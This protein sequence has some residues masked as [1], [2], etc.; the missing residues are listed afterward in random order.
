MG[1]KLQSISVEDNISFEHNY[2][3]MNECFGRSMKGDLQQATYDTKDGCIA[4]FPFIAIEKNGKYEAGSKNVN[5]KNL[6][7]DDGT[8]ITQMLYPGEPKKE[9]AKDEPFLTRPGLPHHTFMKFGEHNFKYVGTFVKDMNASAPRSQLLRRV[10]DHIDLS[11]WYK[12]HD[13][14]YTDFSETGIACLKQ[15]YIEN[16]LNKHKEKLKEFEESGICASASWEEKQRAYLSQINMREL[17]NGT[18]EYFKDFFI[19]NLSRWLTDLYGEQ[20]TE[21]DLLNGSDNREDWVTVLFNLMNDKEV[22]KNDKVAACKWGSKITGKVMALLEPE[23]YL[24]TLSEFDTELF[25]E[26]LKMPYEKTEP[27]ISKQGKLYFWK[28]CNSQTMESWS[29]LKYYDFLCFYGN[30]KK[31]NVKYI[32]RP[33][34]VFEER[35]VK[36]VDALEK[37]FIETPVTETPDAFC[38][39]AAP[40]PREI[41]VESKDK[42]QPVVVRHMDRRLNAL[43]KAGFCCEIDPNHP[44]FIRRNS[45]KQYTETHHL[46]PIEF[47]NQFAYTL[48]TEENIVSLCS[49]CHNQLHYG[50][51]AEVLLKKLYDARI[52]HL[53]KAGIAQTID[54]I[55]I[56]F[57]QLLH[58]YKLD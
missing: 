47:S 51:G 16:N 29:V 48:D 32:Q 23:Y 3:A 43:V 40:R 21:A 38:Y 4:W 20:I 42:K 2:Q 45:D 44:T 41:N 8:L 52:E 34:P 19:P 12:G 26:L 53:K 57:E 25:L 36:E 49:N 5:W 14:S 39:V 55:E 18:E 33:K 31:T 35:V 28:T 15:F 27:L 56:T 46:I 37:E 17:I 13:E 30:S 50:Q 10:S 11:V 22:S 58:M 9:D 7:S 1:K 54:G 6:I 24:Y